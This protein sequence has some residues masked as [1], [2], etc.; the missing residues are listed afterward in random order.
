MVA[1]LGTRYADLTIEHQALGPAGA[2]IVTA[3]GTT[4]QEIIEVAGGAEVVL[5]GAA[6]R[7]DAATL[8]GLDAV[9][10]VRYGVG[11]DSIDLDAA[12]R[13][14]MWVVNVA[15]YGTE[16]V[17]LHTVALALGAL[18]RIP[19]ADR[20]VRSGEWG[21][22]GLR[23]LRL[24][25]GLTLGIVGYGRIGRRVGE[26]LAALGFGTVLVADPFATPTDP[27]IAHVELDD[28]LER[29]DVV[30]LHSSP[31]AGGPLLDAGRLGRMRPGSVL[32]NTARGAL[33]D[34]DALIA[35]LEHGVPGVAALDVY[36][37][38][39]PA[40][41]LNGAAAD[42]LI[43]TPHMAWYTEE[44]ERDLRAQAAAEALRLLRGEHPLNAVVEPA[45]ARGR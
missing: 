21:L 27:T 23:P 39:P 2:V 45:A 24:L 1:I 20:R 33:V 29:A 41:A 12:R 9:G 43:L 5:A 44:T 28:L 11:V 26:L 4:R 8:D 7:F 38:E 34:L 15:D 37:E 3:P 10:I 18:R 40:L 32:V 19:M 42:R 16:A 14:G 13:R 6:P 22:G 35:G 31:P 25:S 36:P 17:A 30:T